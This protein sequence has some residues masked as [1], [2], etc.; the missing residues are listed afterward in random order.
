MRGRTNQ[1]W[2]LGVFFRSEISVKTTN[3]GAIF[4]SFYQ[5][6]HGFC[7]WM[8]NFT[9]FFGDFDQIAWFIFCNSQKN[10][11]ITGKWPK[12]KQTQPTTS[13][14]SSY[15]FISHT[16]YIYSSYTYTFIHTENKTNA[17]WITTS[18]TSSY[19]FISPSNN[20]LT[21]TIRT[22]IRT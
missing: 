2:I 3:L 6:K 17:A 12:T 19:T 1:T 21:T 8:Q 14:T 15:T 13:F 22:T 9:N 4:W 11:S 5:H 18:F 16:H 10:R 7:F 20:K